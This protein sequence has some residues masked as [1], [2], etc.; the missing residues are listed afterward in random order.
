MGCDKITL[1]TT[2]DL[3]ICMEMAH[4]L[5]KLHGVEGGKGAKA[6]VQLLLARVPLSL[7]LLEA[8]FVGAG[9]VAL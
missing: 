2:V 9:E 6:A 4:V 8:V 3:L 5:L 1:L 7:V